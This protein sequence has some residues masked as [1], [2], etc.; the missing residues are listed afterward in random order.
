[1][2]YSISNLFAFIRSYFKLEHRFLCLMFLRIWVG[3]LEK[4]VYDNEVVAWIEKTVSTPFWTGLTL[5]SIDLRK[6]QPSKRKKHLLHNPLYQVDGRIAY[7]G[8][9]FS[10]PMD[11]THMVDQLQKLEKGLVHPCLPITGKILESRVRLVISSGLV[12]LKLIK[13]A[14][15]RRHIVVQLIAMHRDAGHPDY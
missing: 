15:V 2:D 5:F 3:Y 8:Q 4:W 14:T 7:K 6:A 12:D 13:Q 11:W 1:M 9:L 10:A